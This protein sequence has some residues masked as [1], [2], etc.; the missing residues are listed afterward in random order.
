MEIL[1]WVALIGVGIAVV[2]SVVSLYMI[3]RLSREFDDLLLDL[4][5]SDDYFAD[6]EM[7]EHEVYVN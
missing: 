7:Y 2:V 3:I 6:V 4:V 1:L 5:E